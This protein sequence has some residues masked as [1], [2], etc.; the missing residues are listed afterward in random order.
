M[1]SNDDVKRIIVEFSEKYNFIQQADI[2]I[3]ESSDFN[4]N[5]YNLINKKLFVSYDKDFEN[6]I[7]FGSISIT[8][9]RDE[10]LKYYYSIDKNTIFIMR[11]SESIT[12]ENLLPLMVG[13]CIN[14]NLIE[15]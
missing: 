11:L 4:E 14:H 8:I 9:D 1:I 15:R 3:I 2:E 12:K 7:E 13:I 6:T 5:N 10:N